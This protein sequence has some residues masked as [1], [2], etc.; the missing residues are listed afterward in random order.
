MQKNDDSYF[1]AIPG[2]PAPQPDVVHPQPH[3]HDDGVAWLS[4]GCKELL[5]E[6]GL[7]Y[8]LPK[9]QTASIHTV[10]DLMLIPENDW[11]RMGIPL[12]IKRKILDRLNQGP[13]RN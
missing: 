6:I 9:F 1:K 10:E 13:N 2:I 5:A 4:S 3:G 7:S 11:D 12:G 8:L